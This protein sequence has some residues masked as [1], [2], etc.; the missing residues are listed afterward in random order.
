M[1]QERTGKQRTSE[2]QGKSEKET[3]TEAGEEAENNESVESGFG[4]LADPNVSTET[5]A[6]ENWSIG[7]SPGFSTAAGQ[8]GTSVK[9]DGG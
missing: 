8:V 1:G 6:G 3:T 5:A 7:S 4:L 9:G 2:G